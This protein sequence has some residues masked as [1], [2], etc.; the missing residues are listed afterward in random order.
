[1]I[2]AIFGLRSPFVTVALKAAGEIA[3]RDNAIHN[4]RTV[5]NQSLEQQDRCQAE[6]NDQA[7]LCGPRIWAL[8]RSHGRF[9]RC[10]VA[11]LLPFVASPRLAN[12][13]ANVYNQSVISGSASFQNSDGHMQLMTS[14]K[15]RRWLQYLLWVPLGAETSS[16]EYRIGILVLH[17]IENWLRDHH[18]PRALFDSYGKPKGQLVSV[19]FDQTELEKALAYRFFCNELGLSHSLRQTR[20]VHNACS[21]TRLPY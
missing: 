2:F 8:R 20:I 16:D 7:Y 12:A 6:I 9:G 10:S 3:P 21:R 13:R 14:A 4:S 17:R 1:M 5:Y 18:A 15:H 19:S 11:G